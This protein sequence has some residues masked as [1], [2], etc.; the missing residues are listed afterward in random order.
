MEESSLVWSATVDFK[1]GRGTADGVASKAFPDST[2][3]AAAIGEEPGSV[4]NG[5]K[6][7]AFRLGL[8][9]SETGNEDGVS[10][11]ESVGDM[12]GGLSGVGGKGNG[13]IGARVAVNGAEELFFA[14]SFALG[15][16][17]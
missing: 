17:V 5:I 13:S 12:G 4:S 15:A 16:F 11:R 3:F 9:V 8:A 1:R 2:T 6:L 14:C 10:V 7:E